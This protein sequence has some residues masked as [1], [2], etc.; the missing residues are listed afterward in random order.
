MQ[1][2]WA[3]PW[4]L[5]PGALTVDVRKYRHTA[6]VVVSPPRFLTGE[7]GGPEAEENA[8]CQTMPGTS[9]DQNTVLPAAFHCLLRPWP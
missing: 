7:Q 4:V 8:V 3:R 5:A 1:Y 6:G 9:V 2:L